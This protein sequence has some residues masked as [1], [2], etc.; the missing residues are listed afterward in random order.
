MVAALLLF[1]FYIAIYFTEVLTP[2]AKAL[3]LGSKWNL[4]GTLYTLAIITGG[5]F[6]LRRHGNSRYQL[7]RTISVIFFQIVFAFSIPLIMQLLN[8][9]GF[10]FSIFW[11]LKIDYFYPSYI[12][13][14]PILLIL[15]AF[16]TSI[17]LVAGRMFLKNSPWCRSWLSLSESV[18]TAVGYVAAADWRRRRVI[19]S[20]ISQANPR[21]RGAS[22]NSQS[23]RS[24]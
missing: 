24:S 13:D 1:A 3:Q 9:K 18:G 23:T 2:V 5:I 11:P 12:L 19:P 8:M 20:A 6:F 7:I 4:Y 10:T 21:K 16:L 15:Y 14:Y 17:I 22:S